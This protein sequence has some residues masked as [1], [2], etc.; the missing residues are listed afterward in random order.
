MNNLHAL[1]KRAW[2]LSLHLDTM[3]LLRMFHRIGFQQ[4]NHL[5]TSSHQ[6]DPGIYF[7]SSGLGD[8]SLFGFKK[9]NSYKY[10]NVFLFHLST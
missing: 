6:A 1:C 4:W 5:N 8:I 9:F 10:T 3:F 7:I 2:M